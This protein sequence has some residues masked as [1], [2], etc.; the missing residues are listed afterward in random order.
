MG[1]SLVTA[2]A[3]PRPGK[4]HLA[5]GRAAIGAM[6]RFGGD[7]ANKCI[8]ERM[9]K[10][11]L[12]PKGLAWFLRGAHRRRCKNHAKSAMRNECNGI[13]KNVSVWKCGT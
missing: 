8:F 7:R 13:W 5:I 12:A 4:N 6:L 10:N 2:P 3:H 1:A 11:A 9:E